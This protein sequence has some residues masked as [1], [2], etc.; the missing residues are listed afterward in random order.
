MHRRTSFA[1]FMLPARNVF[2]RAHIAMLSRDFSSNLTPMKLAFFARILDT[3]GQLRIKQ[4][5]PANRLPLP[6]L[7]K[8]AA[9]VRSFTCK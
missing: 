6:D 5:W 3:R 8:S 7:G 2:E 4:Q 9:D 1:L